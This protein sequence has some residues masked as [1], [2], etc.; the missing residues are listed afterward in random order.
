MEHFPKASKSVTE[1][2]HSAMHQ[3]MNEMFNRTGSEDKATDHLRNEVD[4]FLDLFFCKT[5][6]VS[7]KS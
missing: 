2:L 7:K 3:Y 4:I 6:I 5:G 1:H